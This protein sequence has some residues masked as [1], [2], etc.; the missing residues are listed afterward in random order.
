MAKF[1]PQVISGSQSFAQEKLRDIGELSFERPSAIAIPPTPGATPESA[2]SPADRVKIVAPAQEPWR[3]IC[4]LVIT[5]A[6][7][8]LH[9]G[10]AWFISPRTLIT[11]GHCIS[12]FSP[13]KPANGKVRSI[14]V[15]PARNGETNAANS[16][17]GWVDVPEQNLFAHSSWVSGDLNFDYGAIVL[18]AGIKPLGDSQ[19]WFLY[20]HFSD[21][22]L[23]NAEAVLAG[24]PDNVQEGTQWGERNLIKS[25]TATRVSYDIFTFAGQSGS[26]V[27]FTYSNPDQYVACAIHNWGNASLNSGVRINPQVIEQLNAWASL[28]L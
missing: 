8:S 23:V 21:A 18:P 26:P 5:A 11:A 15:M 1:E 14:R 12:V 19:K 27:F 2:A 28:G 7:G 10:T 25:L 22:S 13:G 6:D 4:D 17:F 16:L 9:S 20:G 3:M 24:Y